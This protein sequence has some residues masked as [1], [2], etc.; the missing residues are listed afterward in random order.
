[1]D[2]IDGEFKNFEEITNYMIKDIKNQIEKL[3]KNEVTNVEITSNIKSKQVQQIN[4][5]MN[6]L[7][8]FL[9]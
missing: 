5:F 2:E 8:K 6:M 1:M 7:L 3:N 9:I 4:Q